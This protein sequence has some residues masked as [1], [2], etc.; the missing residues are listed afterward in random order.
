M[1]GVKDGR[2]GVEWMVVG[3]SFTWCCIPFF[4]YLFIRSSAFAFLRSRTR[5]RCPPRTQLLVL[6]SCSPPLPIL[7]G[8]QS[9]S[10]HRIPSTY[11]AYHSHHPSPLTSPTS[12]D[13]DDGA[14]H[15]NKPPHARTNIV[16]LSNHSTIIITSLPHHA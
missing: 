1:T 8:C 12:H 15:L 2:C 11:L 16:F 7:V 9:N 10:T 3:R 4:H 13:D 14:P 6:P 5:S